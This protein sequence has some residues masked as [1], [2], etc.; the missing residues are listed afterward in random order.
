MPKGNSEKQPA[1]VGAVGM[2]M[3]RGGIPRLVERSP[4]AARIGYELVSSEDGRSLMVLEASERL[5]NSM[6][7]LHGELL[8]DFADEAMGWALMSTLED[9]ESFTTLEL[10]INYLRPVWDTKLSAHGRVVNR[11]PRVAL[12]GLEEEPLLRK[13]KP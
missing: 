4:V 1:R 9:G 7:T 8:C 12:A 2:R 10:K 5:A 11:S 6:G 13:G 3:P